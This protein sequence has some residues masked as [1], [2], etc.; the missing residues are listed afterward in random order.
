MIVKKFKFKIYTRL[1]DSETFAIT[2]VEIVIL[3][4]MITMDLLNVSIH[5]TKIE[6]G[7]LNYYKLS[8]F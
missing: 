5:N 3:A 2:I 1:S 4:I 6:Y 7:F 8:Q